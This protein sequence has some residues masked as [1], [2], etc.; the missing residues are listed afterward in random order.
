MKNVC[1][2]L[3]IEKVDAILLDLGVSSYQLD[4][5]ERGFSYMNN[6]TLDMRMDQEQKLTAYDVVNNMNVEELSKIIWEYG[7]DK[8]SRRIAEFIVKARP[9]NTT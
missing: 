7:E 4:N 5:T 1:H 3:G 6:C 8:F 2:N 9:I